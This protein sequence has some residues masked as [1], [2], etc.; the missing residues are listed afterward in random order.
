MEPGQSPQEM[1]AEP[2]MMEEPELLPQGADEERA[3]QQEHR[4]SFLKNLRLVTDKLAEI[5]AKPQ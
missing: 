4:H 5:T 3:R 2:Q 1:Q